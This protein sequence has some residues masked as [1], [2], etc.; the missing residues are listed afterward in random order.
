[1]RQYS[2]N[3]QSETGPRGLAI[4]GATGSIGTQTLEVVRL[5]SEQF[6]VRALTCGSNVELLAR[7]VHEFRPE[8][9]VVGSPERARA[10]EG[11]LGA[12]AP[13]VRVLVGQEGLCEVAPGPTWTS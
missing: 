6:D 4:L 12:D 3:G 5:F 9:V 1:M 7:Q 2:R 8:C 10:F 13:D 11:V